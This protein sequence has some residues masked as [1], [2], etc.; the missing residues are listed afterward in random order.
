MRPT[1]ANYLL[2]EDA[3][4]HEV[5]LCMQTGKTIN[6]PDRMRMGTDTLYVR[7]P[8]EME[9]LFAKVPEALANTERI[10]ARC[11]VEIKTG[12]ISLPQFETG[13]GETAEEMLLLLCREGLEK[14]LLHGRQGFPRQAY[15]ERLIMSFCHQQHG[16]HD[17]YLIVWDFSFCP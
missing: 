4:A 14:R 6:S 7:S 13:T 17:Y 5:L 12:E 3:F 1:T 15:L 11:Q 8:S 16:L 9:E 10:A 2:R